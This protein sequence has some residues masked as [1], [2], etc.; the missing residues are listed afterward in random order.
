MTAELMARS[1]P[2]YLLFHC[3]ALGAEGRGM[4]LQAPQMWPP[5]H[6]QDAYPLDIPITTKGAEALRGTVRM[7]SHTASKRQIWEE[8]G[9]KSPG[10]FPI[11]AN[12]LVGN[13]PSLHQ[14]DLSAGPE[15]NYISLMI[16]PKTTGRSKEKGET[17]STNSEPKI[18]EDPRPKSGRNFD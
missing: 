12:C 5:C 10:L 14:L 13:F 1:L 8:D 4:N 9:L 16:F 7:Y 11:A 18:R 2:G 3:G 17:V 15:S 6:P